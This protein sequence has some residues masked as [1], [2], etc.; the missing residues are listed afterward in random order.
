M[1]SFVPL[2]ATAIMIPRPIGLPESRE[3]ATHED[4]VAQKVH[5]SPFHAGT[6][7]VVFE[8]LVLFAPTLVLAVVFLNFVL[9]LSDG[10]GLPALDVQDALPINAERLGA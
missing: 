7:S 4:H 1:F 9:H 6:S 8:L 5:T 10:C 3:N 2:L